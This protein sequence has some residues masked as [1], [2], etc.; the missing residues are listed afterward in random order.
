MGK[1]QTLP[2]EL[3]SRIAAGEVIERPASVLKELIENSI[4]ASA[5][6]I[7]VN[8]NKSGKNLIAV[9]D[10]GIGIE[11]EDIPLLFQRHSTSKI[12]K[13]EDLFRI[14]SMGF[15][16]EALY[17][18]GSVSE[19]FLRTKIEN[20][21]TGWEIHV[22]NGK[23]TEPKPVSMQKGTEVQVHNLFSNVPARRKFLKSDT[24]EFRKILDFFI[25][26]A[27][28]HPSIHFVLI[29]NKKTVFDLS[30]EQSIKPR[31]S[32]IFNINQEHLL[33]IFWRSID[34]S[35]SIEA[36][37]GDI[38]LQR[39]RKDMQFIFINNRP[40]QHNG[41]SFT[42]N[43]VYR[44]LLPPEM[45]PAFAFFFNLKK[46]DV[47]INVHPSKREVKIRNEVDILN[48]TRK[49]LEENL[50]KKA[51]PRVLSSRMES[52]SELMQVS[53]KRAE[54]YQKETMQEPALIQ[55]Q[56][57]L[58]ETK[59]FKSKFLQSR[60]IATVLKTYLIFESTDCIFMVDQH[61]AHER[62]I[63]EKLLDQA[64]KG[65]IETEQLLI[66]S[67]IP[68]STHEM[69]AWESGGKI[70][71]E[72]IGFITTQWDT[73]IIAVH[74][75]P[76]GINN[77]ELAVRN[78]LGEGK[79]NLDIETLLKKACRGSTMAGENLSLEEAESLKVAL[80]SCEQPLVCPHGRP[81][82]VEIGKKFIEKQFFR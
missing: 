39:S 13:F 8:L 33:E 52:K 49:V 30:G 27:I 24:T 18:I 44:N 9:K 64:R 12:K 58:P 37:I 45:Y 29:H 4:D 43:S 81:T 11:K 79:I 77:P 16:G 56:I 82:I 17:S 50:I 28:V 5:K 25:P 26:Y 6:K 32:K 80:I 74:S 20:E 70:K 57:E 71:L 66:P 53:E 19:V 15:R 40:V 62:I 42:I 47:D 73:R 55:A 51:R 60:F 65:K 7:V 54:T 67:S 34:N 69:I 36:V 78:I 46:D 72:E 75:C 10:D 1:I 38:N 21:Q 63:F 41:L 48:L 23:K 3:I 31:M 61:A 2:E 22:K 59:D 35:V 68:L 76:K 14:S